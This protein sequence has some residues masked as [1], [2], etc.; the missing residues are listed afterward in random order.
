M[1][2]LWAEEMKFY[3]KQF[4]ARAEAY[5]G[6]TK[7]LPVR[8]PPLKTFNDKEAATMDLRPQ[9]K[10]IM[11]PDACHRWHGMTSSPTLPWQRKW[12]S[13]FPTRGWKSLK[14][15]VILHWWR[16]LKSFIGL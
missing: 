8:V 16:S 4:D 15:P 9:L 13:T 10:D 6:R 14:T 3:F 2:R 7:D 11:V 5:H 1:A 12:S